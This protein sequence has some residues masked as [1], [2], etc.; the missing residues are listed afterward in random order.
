MCAGWGGDDSHVVFGENFPR[1]K[2]SVRL[3]VQIYFKLQ[4]GFYPMAVSLRQ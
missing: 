1:E 4:M 3:C 2:G